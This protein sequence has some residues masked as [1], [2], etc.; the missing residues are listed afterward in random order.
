MC[1][2]EVAQADSS[3]G[4]PGVSPAPPAGQPPGGMEPCQELTRLSPCRS[5]T[6]HRPDTSRGPPPS[7]VRPACPAHVVPGHPPLLASPGRTPHCTPLDSRLPAED[8]QELQ[9]AT[10]L[11]RG[12][13]SG[14][15]DYDYS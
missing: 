12:V 3:A 4:A 5:H 11:G 1:A 13:G 10:F 14:A 2:S 9:K 8:T 15:A 6:F 7:A